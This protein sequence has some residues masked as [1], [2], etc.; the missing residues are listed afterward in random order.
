M[1]CIIKLNSLIIILL[2]CSNLKAQDNNYSDTINKAINSS[3]LEK[4]INESLV[5]YIKNINESKYRNPDCKLTLITDYYMYGFKFCPEI[6]EMDVQFYSVDSVLKTKDR[7]CLIF[8][9]GI[10]LLDDKI[11]I[12]FSAAHTDKRKNKVYIAFG[13]GGMYFTYKYSYEEKRWK[14]L[15]ED[16][17]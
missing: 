16:E 12:L 15:R 2:I 13:S 11:I 1:Q 6:R 7:A 3:Y 8:F 17:W 5:R 4:M 10:K 14:L 9:S